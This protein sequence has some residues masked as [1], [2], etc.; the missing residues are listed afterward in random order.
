MASLRERLLKT[1]Y[2][3]PETDKTCMGFVQGRS[4]NCPYCEAHY[5]A[6]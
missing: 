1:V 3:A 2:Y 5:K 4:I 6:R